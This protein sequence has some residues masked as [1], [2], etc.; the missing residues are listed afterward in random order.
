VNPLRGIALKIL[1]VLVF[2]TMAMCIKASAPHVPPGQAVFFRSFFAI[3]VIVA[4]LV[5][6]GNLRHGFDTLYPMG[7]VWR[8]LVGTMAMGLGFT[9]L[10][11]LPLPEATALGYAAPLLTVIFAAMFLGEQVRAFR[12]SAVAVG[13]VGV[14][15]VLSPR[16]TVTRLE[17]ATVM[18]TIG[19]MAALGGAVFAALAQVFVRKLIHTEGTAT[20]VFYF[21]ATASV[22]SLLT[23]PFGWVVPRVGEA[24]LLVG[25]GILGGIGQILLTES[26]RHAETGVIAPFEY[27]SMLLAL[28]LGY[29]VFGEVPSY[30]MLSGALLI[31]SAG[32]FII[33]RERRLG[34]QRAGA[35]KVITPQG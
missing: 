20:I 3:P 27:V 12:L 16:M 30:S 5:A 15:I 8:G 13:L 10:G 1:S 28:I 32:L 9:A 22:L 4:W 17:D 2:T 24:A 7:H 19:A 14:V 26:Y 35:R 18:Y 25:A 33:W 34:L 23:L 6:T 31:V 29:T 11:L 21:S